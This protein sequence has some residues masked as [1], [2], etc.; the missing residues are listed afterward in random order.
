MD[1]TVTNAW[2]AVAAI[3]L[4]VIAIA[5]V[6][7]LVVMMRAVRQVSE[8]AS[9]ASEAI[10]R[11]SREV[12]PL[13]AQTSAVLGDMHDLVRQLKHADE[14]ATSAVERIGNQWRR[15]SGA[16]RSGLWPAIA[17]ARGAAAVVQWITGHE[18]TPRRTKGPDSAQDNAAEAQFTYEG[19]GHV[20]SG[21]GR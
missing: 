13:A 9:R 3:S 5:V 14:V 18:S 4:L 20:R 1:L 15:I 6:A 7:T 19:G 16:A 12:S 17:V 2:L 11:V 21:T 10:E 8:S